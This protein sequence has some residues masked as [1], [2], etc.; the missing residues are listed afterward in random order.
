M[1]ER[2]KGFLPQLIGNAQIE[3]TT[4]DVAFLAAI[5]QRKY[6]VVC[7][8]PGACRWSAAKKPIPGGNEATR[9]WGLDE[10]RDFVRL[11]QG[12]DVPIVETTQEPDLVPLLRQALKLN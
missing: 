9:G 2:S 4:D 10:Y 6:D 3:T 5:S 7:F 8:A 12:A 1:A 11:H